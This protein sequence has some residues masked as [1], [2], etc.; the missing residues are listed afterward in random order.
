[1][2]PEDGQMQSTVGSGDVQIS[3]T[4]RWKQLMISWIR[5]REYMCVLELLLCGLRHSCNT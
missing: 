5:P 4:I 1:L 3:D 2:E